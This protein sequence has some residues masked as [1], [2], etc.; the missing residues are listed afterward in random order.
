MDNT[1]SIY[2][3][4]IL[5]GLLI[6]ILAYGLLIPKRNDRFSPSNENEASENGAL[7]VLT[8]LSSE[9]HDALPLSTKPKANADRKLDRIKD[10]L[11]RS[12]NPWGVTAEEFAFMR[13]VTGLIGAVSGAAIWFAMFIFGLWLPWYAVVAGAAII[14]FFYPYITYKET[15]AERDLD[16]KK[17]LPEI[18]ELII[19]SVSAGRTFNQALRDS[20]PHL[21]DSHL[22][23][24]FQAVIRAVD[25]GKPMKEALDRFAERAPSTGIV[26]FTR[27][28]QEAN[29][30]DVSLEATLRSRADESRAEL[31]SLIRERTAA[32][33]VKMTAVLTPTLSFALM[34]ILLAPFIT[35]LMKILQ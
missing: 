35:S 27:S 34:I 29:E 3:L 5:T 19:I 6:F 25:S 33:P 12:G 8:I 4:A 24:E 16:F 2:V 1:S 9:I 14:G 32:L 18:L 28:L 10:L 22:K 23:T 17:N 15:A 13:Y 21:K 31:F 11:I 26:T 30:L 20:V 7:R